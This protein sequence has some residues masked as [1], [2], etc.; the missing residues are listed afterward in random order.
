MYSQ[1]TD[2]FEVLAHPVFLPEQSDPERGRWVWAYR[3]LIRNEG[4]APARLVAR[5]W[6]IVDANGHAQSVDGPGVV[7]QTPRIA[8]GDSYEYHSGC[9]LPTPGGTMAGHYVMER[10]DGERFRIEVPPFSLDVPHGRRTL[11]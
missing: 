4:E 10:D 3:I 8:P 2:G 6:D 9:P 1:R 7:G 11:N 5:H